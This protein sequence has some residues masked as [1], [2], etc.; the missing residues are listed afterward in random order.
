MI[1]DDERVSREKPYWYFFPSLTVNPDGKTV[2]AAS[3]ARS[4]EYYG[5]FYWVK[6][7]AGSFSETKMLTP[8]GGK[9]TEDRW[10]D[11]TYTSIDPVG[12]GEDFVWTVQQHS[13]FPVQED[14]YVFFGTVIS[15]IDLD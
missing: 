5:T 6:P 14:N 3:G 8:G 11:Y 13:I 2:L 4:N 7:S 15:K 9:F 10:G 12:G 1:Y